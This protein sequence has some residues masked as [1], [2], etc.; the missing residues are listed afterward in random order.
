MQNDFNVQIKFP[1]KDQEENVNII[2]ISG[3]KEKID[4]ARAA[5]IALIPVTQE[6]PLDAMFHSDLIGQ[7]G[8]GLQELTSKYNINIKVPQKPAE[9]EEPTSKFQNLGWISP[10]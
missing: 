3:R 10:H 1:S 6:Y 5:I 8:A 9:G 7:K 2:T 4:E